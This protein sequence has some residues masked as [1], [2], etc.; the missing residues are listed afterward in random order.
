MNAMTRTLGAGRRLGRQAAESSFEN[1]AILGVVILAGLTVLWAVLGNVY[2]IVSSLV[3]M[4]LTMLMA[5]RYTR[6]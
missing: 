2:G 3:A 4:G 5:V 6:R 1:P